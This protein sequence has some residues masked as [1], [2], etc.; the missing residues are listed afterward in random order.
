MR[1]LE[2]GGGCVFAA[3]A[4]GLAVYLMVFDDVHVHRWG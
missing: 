4:K 2:G 1:R 3:M